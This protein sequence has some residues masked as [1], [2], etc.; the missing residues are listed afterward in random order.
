MQINAPSAQQETGF[1]QICIFIFSAG[2]A[3]AYGKVTPVCPS[4]LRL[5]LGLRLGR[6]GRVFTALATR[7]VD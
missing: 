1:V 4:L 6:L 2:G 3:L 5:R 7:I